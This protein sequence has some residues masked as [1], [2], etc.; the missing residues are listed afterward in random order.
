MVN[1][2]SQPGYCLHTFSCVL[3]LNLDLNRISIKI[4]L[5]LSPVDKLILCW[6]VWR[7]P[8]LSCLHTLY[9]VAVVFKSLYGQNIYV[10]TKYRL[11]KSLHVQFELVCLYSNL[12]LSG[13][14][15]YVHV[16]VF[17]D[18][19][20]CIYLVFAQRYY[21]PLVTGHLQFPCIFYMFYYIWYC[22]FINVCEGF[23]W[24]ISRPSLTCKNKYPANIVHVPRQL[25]R[26]KLT[27]NINPSEHEWIDSIW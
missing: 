7:W 5:L 19:F 25:T 18:R 11:C 22:K 14:V 24:R 2:S 16:M 15:F 13:V 12:L 27:A 10:Y 21:L 8:H 20:H 1:V 17:Q 23:I 26:P 3:V 6:A 4:L 9:T